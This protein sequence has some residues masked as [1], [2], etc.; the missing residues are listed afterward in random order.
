MADAKDQKKSDKP[1]EAPLP[2]STEKQTEIAQL[3]IDVESHRREVRTLLGKIAN[4][5]GHHQ[6]RLL[7]ENA[8]LKSRITLLEKALV[9]L[10]QERLKSRSHEESKRRTEVLRQALIEYCKQTK[11]DQELWKSIAY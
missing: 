10:S 1:E 2:A 4:R 7:E 3:R 5:E 6:V 8:T 9:F 11:L